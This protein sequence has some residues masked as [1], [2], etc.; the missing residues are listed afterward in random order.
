MS[1]TPNITSPKQPPVEGADVVDAA[2]RVLQERPREELEQIAQDIGVDPGEF[3]SP[4]HL[5]VAIQHRREMIAAMDVEA[6]IEV[7]RWGRRPIPPKPTREQL[8][9]EI[10]QMKSMRFTGLSSRGLTVLAVMRGIELQGDDDDATL[11]RRL[12]KQEGF[13]QRLARKRRAW[14]GS[15]ISGM[16]GDGEAHG[17]EQFLPPQEPVKGSTG[18]PV[19]PPALEGSLK[20]EI[21]EA[22]VFGGLA[23][24][25][26]R[27]ADTFLNQKLDEIEAR[28][29]RKL[30]EIDRR[31][32]E[33]RDKEVANRIRILKITLWV[34]VIVSVLS[35]IYTYL[36][37]NLP[38]LFG[39]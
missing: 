5:A 34:S 17:D 25:V 24:R 13:F 29:D 35:L 4:R 39:G 33:W 26:K 19:V 6:M 37:V 38:T 31:L 21:E 11:I 14:I 12:K 3:R 10:A 20:D 23:S 22:G 27:Q 15:V 32:A 16:L 7:M 28:I 30:D 36:R 2:L 8:A 9:L 18:A 1:S